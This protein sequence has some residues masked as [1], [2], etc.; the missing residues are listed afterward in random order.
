MEIDKLKEALQGENKATII[1]TVLQSEGAQEIIRQRENAYFEDN[2]GSVR[3]EIYDK[4]DA[5]LKEAG[6]DKGS[7]KTYE[8]LKD[9]LADY[10]GLKD[11]GATSTDKMK[12]LQKEL[13]DLRSKGGEN[14]FWKEQHDN[15]QKLHEQ[16]LSEKDEAY[17]TLKTHIHGEKVNNYLM[18]G[19]SGYEFGVSQEVA[20]VFVKTKIDALKGKVEDRDGV[21]V[22]I[23]PEGNPIRDAQGKFITPK[24]YWAKELAPILKTKKS[25][26]GGAKENLDGIA[27]GQKGEQKLT[28]D[29]SKF[30]TK[31]E[32]NRHASETLLKQGITRDNGLFNKLMVEAYKEYNVNE[33]PK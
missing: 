1:D 28:L 31:G 12:E 3:R 21:M 29:R 32:F 6:F 9:F 23:G 17:N 10:K 22:I 13:E 8:V 33:L 24:E 2:Q 14:T 16:K 5:D 25:N 7:K 30:S 19:L 27:K 11:N 4:I 26:G 20:D 18:S 15:L